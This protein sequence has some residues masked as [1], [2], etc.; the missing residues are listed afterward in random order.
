MAAARR[1]RLD[2]RVAERDEYSNRSSEIESRPKPQKGDELFHSGTTLWRRLGQFVVV[3]NQPKDPACLALFRMLYGTLMVIDCMHERGMSYAID[4]WGDELEC[5]FPLFDFMRPLPVAWMCILYTVM[6]LGAAGIAVGLFFRFSCLLFVVPYWYVFLLDKTAWNNHSYL[7]GL[8]GTIFLFTDAN[9]CWSLDGLMSRRLRNAHVPLWNY[10]LLRTQIFFVY[11][12]AGLKKLDADWV[13]G[14]SMQHLSAEWVFDP[15]RAFLTAEQIDL[16]I[17]H[18]GGLVIDLTAGFLL[19]YGRTR[20][21]GTLMVSSFHFMN[22]RIFTIGMFPYAMLST[23]VLFYAA[24]WPRKCLSWLLGSRGLQSCCPAPQRSSHCH[25]PNGAPVGEAVEGS[26]AQ[27]AAAASR[28][29]SEAS[30]VR[31]TSW[32]HKAGAMF[33]ALFLCWQ[34]FLPYSHFLTQG[35]NNWTNGLYGYSWDMMVHSWSLQHIKVTYHNK[36]TGRVGYLKPEAFAPDKRWASHADM[37]KQ[38]AKCLQDRLKRYDLH[39]VEIYFDV[40]MSLNSRFQQRMFDP[41]MDMLS[42]EWHPF[43]PVPWQRP[44]LSELSDWR[45]RLAELKTKYSSEGIRH[46]DAA[47][48]ADFPGGKLEQYIDKHL[49][50]TNLTVLKGEIIY[51]LE[52]GSFNM[53]LKE[54]ETIMVQSDKFHTVTTISPGPSC[55]M[56]VFKNETLLRVTQQDPGTADQAQPTNPDAVSPDGQPQGSGGTPHLYVSRHSGTNQSYWEQTK[57]FANTS[58]QLIEHSFLTAKLAIESIVTG[59]PIEN[60]ADEHLPSQ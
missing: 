30:S 16:Y 53:T 27:V 7:F 19:C 57:A 12:I 9:R 50:H 6:L 44:L 5:R 46:G 49:V 34:V 60:L 58:R 2:G 47:F 18:L 26:D 29:H 59:I 36:D 20:L 56:Y 35:Y 25:Y 17:V 14:Y 52:G 11:F 39:N 23:T 24:D 13:N 1:R 21:L 10:I 38:Y 15:F 33:T 3:M 54:N 28:Q 43:K 45:T 41:D 4:R 55:Y 48:F 40:W 37:A 8:L 32:L 31:P 42:A 51:A 22:S